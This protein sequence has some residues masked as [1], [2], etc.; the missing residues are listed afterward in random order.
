MTLGD[1][2]KV[3]RYI[4]AYESSN[5]EVTYAPL[6]KLFQGININTCSFFFSHHRI[7][8]QIVVERSHRIFGNEI[9]LNERERSALYYSSYHYRHVNVLYCTNDLLNHIHVRDA[10]LA[11]LNMQCSLS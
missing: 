5:I 6:G 3:W 1:T 11:E 10:Y 2:R 4:A 8:V 7:I 9:H